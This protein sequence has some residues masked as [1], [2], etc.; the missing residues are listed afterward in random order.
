MFYPCLVENVGMSWW[1]LSKLL[2][3][4][5]I[6]NYTG[7]GGWNIIMSGHVLYHPVSCSLSHL[8][9]LL[10]NPWLHLARPG[11]VPSPLQMPTHEEF[12]LRPDEFLIHHCFY[13][14]LP[15][16]AEAEKWYLAQQTGI[17]HWE[18]RPRLLRYKFA[19]NVVI[20]NDINSVFTHYTRNSICFINIKYFCKIRYPKFVT[21]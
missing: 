21:D 16:G 6:I 8:F 10:C 3:Y 14:A 4:L 11:P 2:K 17:K 12:S 20:D 19:V 5:R 1:L 15:K 18:L 7:A 9:S 13:L